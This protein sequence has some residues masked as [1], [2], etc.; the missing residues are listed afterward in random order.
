MYGPE[1]TAYCANCGGYFLNIN[2]FRIHCNNCIKK[3]YRDIE[4]DDDY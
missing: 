1:I 2:G 3:T 4:D